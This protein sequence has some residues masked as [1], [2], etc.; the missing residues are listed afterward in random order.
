MSVQTEQNKPQRVAFLLDNLNGGG[1]E[2]VTLDMASGFAA[3][4]YDVDLVVCELQGDLLDSVPSSVNLVLIKPTGK[5]AGLMVAL[6]RGG[7]QGLSAILFWVFS[8]RK[9][10]RS[11]RYIRDMTSYLQETRP[12]VISSAIGKSSASLVLAA[13]VPDM[14]T[15][16]YVGIHIALSVRSALSRRSGKGQAYSMA[17]LF[18]YCFPKADGVIAASRG[19]AEDAI[20]FLGLDSAKVSVVYN[21]IFNVPGTADVA[22][23]PSHPWFSPEAPP[24]ILSMGRLVQQ[25]NF[26]LLI[27]AFALVRRQ[28]EVRLVILGGD[29][30]SVEQ[31]THRQELQDLA[32]A[33]GIAEDVAL[34]GYQSDPHAFLRAANVFVLSS[35]FEGFGNVLVEALLAGCPVVSTDCPSGP[36]EILD[37]GEYGTLVPVNDPQSLAAGIL[38]ALASDPHADKLRQRG[39]E[40]SLERAVNGYHQVFFGEPSSVT[41]ERAEAASSVIPS[42]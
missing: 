37:N 1:A 9:I 25:K 28:C 30:S 21:P 35:D 16:V 8:A 36:A 17:P 39:R 31:M 41:A 42:S 23:T 19:V 27:R 29:K 26:P 15:R 18:R 22:A 10:P 3:I 7:W 13:S 20:R 4:G 24:V 12:T 33:L 34:L 5:L 6:R 14:T 32:K 40:F 38:S 2:R 11:F